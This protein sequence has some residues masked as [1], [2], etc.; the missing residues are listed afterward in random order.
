MSMNREEAEK[1]VNLAESEARLRLNMTPDDLVGRQPDRKELMQ[2]MYLLILP[3]IIEYA[4]DQPVLSMRF[5]LIRQGRPQYLNEGKSRDEDPYN[6]HLIMKAL[7]EKIVRVLTGED[8]G[9]ISFKRPDDNPRQ[10]PH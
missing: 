4:E 2:L 5:D 8:D 9:G 10:S 7:K 3:F 1:K 6:T